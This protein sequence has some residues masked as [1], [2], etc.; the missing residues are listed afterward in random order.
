VLPDTQAWRDL[1]A[2]FVDAQAGDCAICQ[3][4]LGER[5]HLDH[6]HTTG[7]VRGALCSSCNTKLGWYETHRR[8]IETYLKAAS[9]FAAHVRPQRLS[10]SERWRKYWQ[11]KE[12]D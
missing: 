5:V 12:F 11:E 6:C 8:E 1:R 10:R 4:E 2:A 9:E 7:F 3:R